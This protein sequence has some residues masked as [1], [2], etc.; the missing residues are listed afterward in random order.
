MYN[1]HGTHQWRNG[2]RQPVQCVVPHKTHID[3]SYYW[4]E[5]EYI[6]DVDDTDVLKMSIL[7]FEDIAYF[8]AKLQ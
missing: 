4:P 2:A 8:Q 1:A 7:F 5:K 6:C 3:E